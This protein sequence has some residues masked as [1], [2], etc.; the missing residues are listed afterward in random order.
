MVAIFGVVVTPVLGEPVA[1]VAPVAPVV[2][3]ASVL[4]PVK[5]LPKP[6]PKLPKLGF[7][8]ARLLALMSDASPGPLTIGFWGCCA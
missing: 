1:P 3:V 5:P 7:T 6:K 8:L 4:G 2:P